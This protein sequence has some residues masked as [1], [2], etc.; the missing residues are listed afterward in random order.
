M[1][2][3]F[4]I[5]LFPAGDIRLAYIVLSLSSVGLLTLHLIKKAKNAYCP[6]CNLDIYN[7]IDAAKLQNI[8]V[9]Y[10]PSCGANIAI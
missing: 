10:C 4:S 3:A 2:I 1:L 6:K 9:C 8:N 5:Q 7:V